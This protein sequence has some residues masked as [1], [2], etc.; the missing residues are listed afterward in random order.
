MERTPKSN[1]EHGDENVASGGSAAVSS[2][3]RES[4]SAFSDLNLS[5]LSKGFCESLE[6]IRKVGA[7]YRRVWLIRH[8]PLEKTKA[9]EDYEKRA[10]SDKS[11]MG[12]EA[13]KKLREDDT[14]APAD[15]SDPK[16]Q[17]IFRHAV[18]QSP[19][20]VSIALCVDNSDLV[21]V[22]NKMTQD[23]IRSDGI[24]EGKFHERSAILS[25]QK[26]A[27]S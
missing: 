10:T 16:T 19:Q 2:R 12:T 9:N 13:M 6:N 22:R 18:R 25:I 3:A 15:V 1:P 5:A 24:L 26:D 14:N 20:G 27:D 7:K 21:R 4:V 11:E 8:F 17:A 23:W